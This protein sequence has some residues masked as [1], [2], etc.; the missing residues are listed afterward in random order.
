MDIYIYI[1]HRTQMTDTLED[2]I[3]KIKKEVSWHVYKY[4]Y[5]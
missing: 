1:H 2:L 5:I 4:Y 3:R